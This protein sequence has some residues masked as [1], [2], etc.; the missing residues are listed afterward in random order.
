M[1]DFGLGVLILIG[2]VLAIM[3]TYM[4]KLRR[5]NRTKDKIIKYQ[6]LI[7]ELQNKQIEENGQDTGRDQE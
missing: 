5:E 6:S 4:T 3:L 1:G 2:V 7:I